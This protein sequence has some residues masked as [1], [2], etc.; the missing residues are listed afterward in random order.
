MSRALALELV[1]ARSSA[2]RTISRMTRNGTSLDPDGLAAT[3]ATSAYGR[4]RRGVFE[5]ACKRAV[6]GELPGE[7]VIVHD[8]LVRVQLSADPL[9]SGDHA[10]DG[11]LALDGPRRSKPDGVA[12][13]KPIA[14]SLGCELD[15]TRAH[16]EQVPRLPDPRKDVHVRTARTTEEDVRERLL[17]LRAAPI[18]DVE[19]DAPRRA[20]LVVVVPDGQGDAQA[21]HVDLAYDSVL[22][23]PRERAVADAVRRPAALDP[24]DHAA[25]ADR[26]AVARLEVRAA[27]AE[28][29]VAHATAATVHFT[30]RSSPLTERSFR[31][32]DGKSS[33]REGLGCLDG[34]ARRLLAA[35]E[36]VVRAC[37][38]RADSGAGARLACDRKRW[39]RPHPGPDGLGEDARRVPDRDRPAQRS[40][41]RRAPT[42]LRLAAQG[43]P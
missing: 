7:G 9:V 38:R 43:A 8:E 32:R 4:L 27:N 20:G 33:G 15:R 3:E 14:V 34:S 29:H 31:P 26:L 41:R 24:V 18:V 6:S 39:A 17:L 28:A 23:P 19:D 35:D 42:A 22:D 30:T 1:A 16:V 2:E 11:L 13:A 25:R 10:G 37:V 5:I 36:D 12:D 40:P 21:G